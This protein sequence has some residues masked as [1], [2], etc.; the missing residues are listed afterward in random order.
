MKQKDTVQ[1]KQPFKIHQ[2]SK[3]KGIRHKKEF[4]KTPFVSPMFGNKVKDVVTVPIATHDPSDKTKKYDAFRTGKKLSEQEAVEKYGTK[5]YEFNNFIN[6]KTRVELLGKTYDG[7]EE[8]LEEKPR[9][10]KHIIAP[11]GFSKSTPIIHEI[12]NEQLDDTPPVIETEAHYVDDYDMEPIEAME[13]SPQIEVKSSIFDRIKITSPQKEKKVTPIIEEVET[14]DVEPV[15]DPPK[16]TF[17]TYQLPSV[18]MLEKRTQNLEDKPDWLLQQVDVINQTLKEFGI[19]G[20]VINSKKG[21]TVT[22]HEISLEAGVSTKKV[23]NIQDNFMMNLAATSIRI[24]APIP[25]KPYV[26]IEVPNVKT[27]MVMFG[28][29]ADDPRFY[30]EKY[31]LKVGLGMDIDGEHIYANI[32]SMPHGLIAGATNSGKSVCVN[33]V[34]ISLLLKNTP[35]DLKL[36]L[37]DPKVVELTPYNDLPH[38]ITPVITD[39]KVASSALAWAVNEMERRYAVFGNNRARNIQAFN[40]R[41]KASEIDEKKMPHIVIIIDE[42][43]DLIMVASKEVEDSIQRITQKARAAG[44]HLIVAT[45]RP[46]AD[47]VKGTIKA[48]IPV[49]L[50]FKVASFVDSTTILDGAGAE[51][52]LG[53]GDMLLRIQDTPKRLQGAYISDDEIY[54]ITD[55]IKAQ[56]K[57]NYIFGHEDLKRQIEEVETIDELFSDVA[58]FVV[59]RKNASIN[60]IQKEFSMGFNRVQSIMVTLEQYGIVSENQG[61][62]AREVLVDAYQLEELLGQ[63]S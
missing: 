3:L 37:I 2:I 8:K 20:E 49:R 15:I 26:G 46:T 57:P 29:I 1:L 14:K 40:D 58:R 43:A 62:K 33:T 55:F 13:E 51:T 17:K 50:A 12:V 42:L 52:L 31:P 59:N 38:L 7:I 41:V 32:E 45:Q 24:E 18:S 48:N 4:E 47:V 61:T 16:K 10:D 11:I 39:A 56:Q 53:R 28:N 22:R 30:D 21:P 34:L 6:E 60:A 23:L 5:Y 63:L 25:G 9:E 36:I 54:A 27:E 44:I 19:E 35:E